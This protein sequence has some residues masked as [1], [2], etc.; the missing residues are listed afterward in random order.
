MDYLIS[1]VLALLCAGLTYITIDE[2]RMAKCKWLKP[3]DADAEYANL[4]IR[5]ELQMI[6]IALIAVVTFAAVWKIRQDVHD[7]YNQLKMYTALL[8]L[9]GAGVVD[10]REYRIPNLFPLVMAVVGVLLLA[11]GLITAQE[12]ALSYVISSVFSTVVVTL[13]MTAASFLTKSGIGAG[14]IKLMAALSLIGGV[15][16]VGGSL[17]FG[18]TLCAVAAIVLL[19]TKKRNLK[20]SLPF[21][22]F[23][24]FGYLASIFTS[25]Y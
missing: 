24:Y 22:P 18:I 10:F 8:C 14:D 3:A 7:I 13:L 16:T 11:L 21:G 12:G 5:R 6:I 4:Q 2:K 20:G 19:L 1:A 15:Y 17:F 23:L 9:T 25:L